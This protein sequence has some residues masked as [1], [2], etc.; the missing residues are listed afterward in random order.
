MWYLEAGGGEG[1]VN[2]PGVDGTAA[3][4]VSSKE[5]CLQ[6]GKELVHRRILVEVWSQERARDRE[7]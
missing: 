3:I 6:G 7:D 2:L 1:V 5:R 4:P